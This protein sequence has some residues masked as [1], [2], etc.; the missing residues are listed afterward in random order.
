MLDEKFCELIRS[1]TGCAVICAGSG[2]DAPHIEKV[3]QALQRYKIPH[4]V[5]ICSAHKQLNSLVELIELINSLEG[6]VA[7]I[8][9]AGGTDALS[10][11]LSYHALS[12]VISCPPD[13]DN[14]STLSNPPGSSNAT[15]VRASNAGRFIAQIYAGV[16][17]ELRRILQ[18][19]RESKIKSLEVA[20]KEWDVFSYDG[21]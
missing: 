9:I 15:I 11:T 7:L 12:P 5:K 14:F 10:G 16:N 20:G 6:S 18:S 21:A 3:S 1:N 19:E 2:S 8:A 13:N 17:P 4:R